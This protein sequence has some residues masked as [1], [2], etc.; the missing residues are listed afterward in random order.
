VERASTRLLAVREA[1]CPVAD[2]MNDP[3]T[4]SGVM[5]ESFM[6]SGSLAKQTITA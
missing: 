5:N 2:V 4:S 1:D 3:F 6:T